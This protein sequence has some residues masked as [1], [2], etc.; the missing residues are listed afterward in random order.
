MNKTVYTENIAD[1]ELLVERNFD[2]RVNEVWKAWTEPEF[3]DQWWAPHPYKAI[4]QSMD[5][6]EGGQWRYHMLGPE[7]DKHWCMMNYFTI[8]LLKRFTCD[9]LFCDEKGNPNTELPRMEWIVGFTES[10]AATKVNV[11]VTFASKEDMEKIVSMGFKEGFSAAH[12]NL[13]K[14]LSR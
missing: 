11:T 12:E 6:R 4:T 3:L 1:N 13:D 7:G 8:E 9:D 14:L 5:F 2:A 10:G